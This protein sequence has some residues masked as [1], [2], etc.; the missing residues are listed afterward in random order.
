MTSNTH[1][2][3]LLTA[4]LLSLWLM[5]LMTGQVWGGWA[6]LFLLAALVLFPWRG[7]REPHEAHRSELQGSSSSA[8]TPDDTTSRI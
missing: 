8:T 3:T 1:L 6:H 4:I 5:L 2:N 7:H